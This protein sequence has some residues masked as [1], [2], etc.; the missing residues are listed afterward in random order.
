MLNEKQNLNLYLL[1]EVLLVTMFVEM[2]ECSN[3][4]CNANTE[5]SVNECCLLREIGSDR[6]DYLC[7]NV[8]MFCDGNLMFD[9][10][11]QRSEDCASN[12]CIDNKC[13]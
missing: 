12:C 13:M 8:P 5:C 11:C 9:S 2:N 4:K 6:W 10:D 3:I 1:F 7:E